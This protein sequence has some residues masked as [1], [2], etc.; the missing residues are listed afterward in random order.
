MQRIFPINNFDIDIKTLIKEYRSSVKE[1]MENVVTHNNSVLV[2]KKFHI[3]RNDVEKDILFNMPYTQEIS[4]R[5]CDIFKFKDMTFRIVMPNTAYNWH[6]DTGLVYHIPLITNIGCHFV[7]ENE[8][9]IMPAG[10]LYSVHNGVPHTF[11]NAGK[12]ER[13]HLTF[14][15]L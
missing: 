1:L 2:Q 8:S 11:V 13:L 14:E 3:I 10:A 12:E 6:M 15:I 4:K 7:Y 9:Y 5:V